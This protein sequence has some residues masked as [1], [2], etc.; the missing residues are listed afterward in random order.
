MKFKAF[1]IYN[2]LD[3]RKV[4]CSLF[5]FI[6][7]LYNNFTSD[8]CR[9]VRLLKWFPRITFGQI[10]QTNDINVLQNV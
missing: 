8:M 1:L 10:M 3:I 4:I 2:K 7:L 6:I 9:A 5:I